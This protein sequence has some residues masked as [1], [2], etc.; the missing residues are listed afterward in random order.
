MEA[1]T[2]QLDVYLANH[3][4][5][6]AYFLPLRQDADCIPDQG[7][8]PPYYTFATQE[9]NT[10]SELYLGRAEASPHD[11]TVLCSLLY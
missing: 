8:K 11:Y 9:M 6:L 4:N 5:N 2:P 10:A 3:W 1:A 7:L